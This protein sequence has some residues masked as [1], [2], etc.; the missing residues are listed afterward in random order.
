MLN[1]GPSRDTARACKGGSVLIT[2]VFPVTT[3]NEGDLKLLDNY[4]KE[5][6]KPDQT[7]CQHQ[8]TFL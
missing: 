3:S 4:N 6:V 7:I 1:S 8:P 2:I 5:K